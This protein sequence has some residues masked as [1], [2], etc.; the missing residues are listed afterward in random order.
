M[1][2]H[3]AKEIKK[4]KIQTLDDRHEIS[5]ILHEQEKRPKINH[6]WY[7]SRQ[8]LNFFFAF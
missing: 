1:Y 8:T 5:R 6:T 3:T 2:K 7:G 4:K